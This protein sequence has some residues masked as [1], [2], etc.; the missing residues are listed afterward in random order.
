MLIEILSEDK[1]GAVV[2][3]RLAERIAENEQDKNAFSWYLA[4]KNPEK[5]CLNEFEE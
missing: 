3:Q 1:S 2:V 5:K 4:F